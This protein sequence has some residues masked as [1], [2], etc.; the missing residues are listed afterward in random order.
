MKKS[1]FG[2]ARVLNPYFKKKGK[3]DVFLIEAQPIKDQERLFVVFES[4]SSPWKQGVW[5]MTD[6]GIV[7]AGQ[8]CKSVT[9]W[10]QTAPTEVECLCHTKDGILTLYNIW[11]SGRGLG[12]E[13]QSMTS[14]FLV[15]DLPN[16]TRYRCNDIG[17]DPD[18][19]KLVIQVITVRLYSSAY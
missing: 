13:S 9:L 1:K 17:T 2:K 18:F 19:S 12:L 4:V 8:H 3:K 7:I 14:G 15:E 11:D 5:L 16:G 6:K 10:Q